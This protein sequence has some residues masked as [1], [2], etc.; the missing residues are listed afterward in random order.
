MAAWC[1]CVCVVL[2]C[3]GFKPGFCCESRSSVPET[4]SRAP[5]EQPQRIY[6]QL[7][8]SVQ[9]LDVPVKGALTLT[10]AGKL[11][12]NVRSLCNKPDEL[13][14]LVGRD[15]HFSS[16][17]V[18]CFTET[19][20]CG[21][22]PGPR[23]RALTHTLTKSGGICF[24]SNNGSL[25]RQHCPP[26]LETFIRNGK[27]F[28]SP[29]SSLHSSSSVSRWRHSDTRGPDAVCGPTRTP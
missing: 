2:S 13:Q 10:H 17:S 1:V 16:P 7:S 18:V 21:S 12:S 22:K 26:D 6:F 8:T 15:R 24:D 23:H 19:W 25:I 9:L 27:P 5:A 11:L 29:L 14:L 20:L 4:S 28:Y 3:F